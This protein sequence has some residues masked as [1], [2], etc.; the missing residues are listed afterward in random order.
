M[1]KSI[2]NKKGYVIFLKLMNRF[3]RTTITF[4]FFALY[5]SGNLFISQIA[6]AL[7]SFILTTWT[8]AILIGLFAFLK[9]PQNYYAFWTVI[10]GLACSTPLFWLGGAHAH[11]LL[12][13]FAVIQTQAIEVVVRTEKDFK[14]G[15]AILILRA[16]LVINFS[17]GARWGGQSLTVEFSDTIYGL[18][19]VFMLILGATAGRFVKKAV[20]KES[21][22]YQ[23]ANEAIE[24][25]QWLSDLMGMVIHNLK[26]PLSVIISTLEISKL[27]AKSGPIT[28]SPK[29]YDRI[30]SNTDKAVK[31]MRDLV[32]VQRSTAELTGQS[33]TLA[34][35]LSRLCEDREVKLLLRNALP[36]QLLSESEIFALQLAIDVFIDN[37]LKHAHMKPQLIVN[38]IGSIH[39][40]DQ[41]PGLTED[42]VQSFGKDLKRSRQ[43]KGSGVGVFFAARVLSKVGWSFEVADYNNGLDIQIYRDKKVVL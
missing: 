38:G 24:S 35:F 3:G 2:S 19:L 40:V 29:E 27:K 10:V 34:V 39:V 23:E 4:L 8:S 20:Q 6:G 1:L 9:N 30:A 15:S 37:S 13:L 32:F 33:T 7:L 28:L 21:D 31:M 43:Q 17:L 11:I 12:I 41:G 36:E 5:I 16:I 14:Y 26:T 22:L 42:Q 18:S 25:K